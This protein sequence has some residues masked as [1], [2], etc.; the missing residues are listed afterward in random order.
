MSET[1]IAVAI[2]DGVE[3]LDVVGPYEVLTAWGA[4]ANGRSIRV[5]TVAERAD[6]VRCAHGLRLLP[7]R[8]WDDVGELDV[9]VLP[10]G[11]A[12]PQAEDERVLDRVRELGENG[13]LLTSVCTGAL[14]LA[15]A[16]LLEGPPGDDA[17]ERAR[18]ARR[19]RRRRSAAGRPL[20]R[21]RRGGHL[22]GRLGRDRH[23]PPPGRAAGLAGPREGRA[24]LHPVRPRASR[25]RRVAA[26]AALL[27]LA[28]SCASASSGGL[29]GARSIKV[30]AAAGPYWPTMTLALQGKTAWVACKTQSRVVRVNTSTG[31]TT[32]S[33]RLRG[34]A[35]AVVSGLG[36]VWA[37]D[38][39]GTL[40]RLQGGKIV[41]RI[42]LNVA[43]AYNIW[44]GGGS[45]WVAADQGA[46]VVRV[47]PASNRVVAR[48]EA[49]DGPASMAFDGG[50]AWVVNHRDTTI[51]RIDL[52]TNESSLLTTL[53]GVNDRAPERM[54]FSHGSLWVTGR[55][56]DLLKVNPTTG[57]VE[58]TIEIGASG[59]DL[60]A[61]GDDLWVP[62]RSDEVDQS[63]FPT[64]DALKRVSMSTGA[65][66]T[67]ARPTSRLDVHGLVATGGAVW[68][69]DNRSG[70]LY[71]VSAG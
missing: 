12:R 38:S 5:D 13:T 40:Y 32:K 46:S 42:A 60:V 37:L 70:R 21:R 24:A 35:I 28:A 67:A 71:R 44:I 54:T 39:G 29:P 9:L 66:T 53:G 43:A 22:G 7:D 20:R 25:M 65:V 1:T 14:I 34:P 2:W 48:I 52:A 51:D 10:G 3:E 23:G 41:K 31:K 36:S 19:L 50:T 18:V 8:T 30:C 56:T 49:G 57:A 59:I 64:M 11:N 16:G 68:I 17:L 26:I 58:Q 47:S 61:V 63:G 33:I 15:A 45:V 27:A 69:A 55:G 4:H 62:T 6:E